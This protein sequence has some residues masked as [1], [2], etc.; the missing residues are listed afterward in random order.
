MVPV[1]SDVTH[2][3]LIGIYLCVWQTITFFRWG[4]KCTT[5][6][7]RISPG[8]KVSFRVEVDNLTCTRLNFVN[9]DHDLILTPMLLDYFRTSNRMHHSE[10]SYH[11]G[12]LVNMSSWRRGASWLSPRTRGPFFTQVKLALREASQGPLYIIRR[13]DCSMQ[14]SSAKNIRSL[15]V[16]CPRDHRNWSGKISICPS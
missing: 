10:L 8:S 1:G 16:R 5:R 12:K 14:Y 6:N 15:Q 3:V 13:W 2:A 7:D 9:T 4:I 11:I